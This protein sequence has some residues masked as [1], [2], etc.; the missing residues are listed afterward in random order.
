MKLF[1]FDCDNLM[2][3][4]TGEDF[5]TVCEVSGKPTSPGADACADFTPEAK[6][7]K[8]TPPAAVRRQGAGNKSN[9]TKSQ[10]RG[11]WR[12]LPR[13]KDE[14]KIFGEFLAKIK[15]IGD[16][17]ARKVARRAVSK[18]GRKD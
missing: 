12:F 5:A 2:P 11:N 14:A 1:C 8:E 18:I 3:K 10:G 4:R 9:Y 15:R 7:T 13:N 17:Y 16:A 6:R